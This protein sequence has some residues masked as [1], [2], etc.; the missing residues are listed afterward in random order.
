MTS[1]MSLI[2][3]NEEIWISTSVSKKNCINKF[4]FTECFWAVTNTEHQQS[5]NII[6]MAEKTKDHLQKATFFMPLS[7]KIVYGYAI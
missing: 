6:S 2:E 5:K 7:V 4:R 1:M 3:Q